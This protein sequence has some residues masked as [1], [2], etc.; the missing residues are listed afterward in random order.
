[1]STESPPSLRE[2]IRT[3]TGAIVL[4]LFVV[5][6]LYA[7]LIASQLL[8]VVYFAFL[9]LLLWLLYRFVR[10]HERIAAAQERRATA[11]PPSTADGND[12]E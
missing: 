3:N 11:A 9:G 7:I 5:A 1:M 12:A 10:A 4:V 2:A 6:A 8:A